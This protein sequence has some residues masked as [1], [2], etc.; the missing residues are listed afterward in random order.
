MNTNGMDQGRVM[1]LCRAVFFREA[2]YLISCQLIRVV[3]PQRYSFLIARAPSLALVQNATLVNSI[4]VRPSSIV[5]RLQI[6]VLLTVHIEQY[7]DA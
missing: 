5:V 7:E 6:P 4:R 3:R 2:W 1:S